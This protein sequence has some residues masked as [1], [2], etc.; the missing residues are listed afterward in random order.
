MADALALV[1]AAHGVHM[2]MEVAV[3]MAAGESNLG[4]PRR[5]GKPCDGCQRMLSTAWYRDATALDRAASARPA[6]A[7]PTC[8]R[9]PRARRWVR[10]PTR[11]R[12]RQIIAPRTVQ[13]RGKRYSSSARR[14]RPRLAAEMALREISGQLACTP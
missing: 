7:A 12:R 2:L 3:K 8:P 11:H 6:S 9:L 10:S 1:R 14:R 13:S 5:D 4:K